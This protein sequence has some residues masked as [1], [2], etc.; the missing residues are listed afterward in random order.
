M[1][2]TFTLSAMTMSPRRIASHE[3]Q[4]NNTIPLTKFI[5]KAPVFT[6]F[7]NL[8]AELRLLI[9]RATFPAQKRVTIKVCECGDAYIL[10]TLIP[11]ALSVCRESRDEA[12]RRYEWAWC[13]GLYVDYKTEIFFF[14]KSAMHHQRLVDQCEASGVILELMQHVASHW[15]DSESFIPFL[16]AGYFTALKTIFMVENGRSFKPEQMR[17]LMVRPVEG[18]DE[19]DLVAPIARRLRETGYGVIQALLEKVERSTL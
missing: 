4:N 16:E 8:P 1:E 14:H 15:F 17:H 9:W 3:I 18:K 5:R 6:R 7:S 11:G 13:P 12:L 19:V 2:S 10:R